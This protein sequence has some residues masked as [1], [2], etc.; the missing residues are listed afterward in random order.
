VINGEL[1]SVKK[2]ARNDCSDYILNIHYAKRWP[3]VS[4]AFGLFLNDVLCGVITFGTPPS[5]PLKRGIAGDDHKQDVLELNRLCLLN[6][7][8]NEASILI[9]RS[10]K[11]LPKN[12]IIVSFADT[13]Q[14]HAGYVYQATNF[15]YCGLSAKRTDWNV[16][17]KEHLHGQTI[18][19]EFRGHENR[20][21]MMREK[22][23]DDFYLSPRPRKHRYIFIVGCKNYKKTI[24]RAL[25][26][27]IESYPT[28]K[29]DE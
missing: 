28:F 22:Y 2:I 10:L 6:N 1:Y 7:V 14:N 17:G 4:Y 23:G 29:G 5:P 15:I 11:L 20:V 9:G 16:K 19:D 12:K 3:S 8:K 24:M 21:K 18:A 13:S 27:K 25:K 26:Y